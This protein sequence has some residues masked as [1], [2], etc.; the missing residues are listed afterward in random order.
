MLIG[1]LERR[2]VTTGGRVHWMA[3]PA[4]GLRVDINVAQDL[5]LGIEIVAVAGRNNPLS[6]D[7][8]GFHDVAEDRN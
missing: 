3:A 8:G 5:V 6:G 4:D 7:T 1:I 2:I